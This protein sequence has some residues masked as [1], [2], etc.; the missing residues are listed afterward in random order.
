MEDDGDDHHGVPMQTID[1]GQAN[2]LFGLAFG[3][4]APVVVSLIL[5]PFR[6]ELDNTNLALI[7]VLVVVVVTDRWLAVRSARTRPGA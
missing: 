5:V 3:A 1:R 6:Q 7:L 4:L 2:R